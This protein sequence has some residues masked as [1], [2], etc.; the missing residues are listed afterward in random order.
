LLDASPYRYSQT[1]SP[2]LDAEAAK[3]ISLVLRGVV[4]EKARVVV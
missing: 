3:A 2:I 4:D 1:A